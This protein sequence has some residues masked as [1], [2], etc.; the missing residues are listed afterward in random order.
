[1]SIGARHELARS[2]SSR[3]RSGSKADKS[4]ILDEFCAATGYTRKHALR[5][6]MKPPDVGHAR[7]H[8]RRASQY[9]ELEESALGRLWPVSGYLGARRLVA[10]LPTLMEALERHGE[11]VPEAA[12]RKKLTSMSVST[13]G[14][15]LKG[16]RS[17][18]KHRGMVTTKPGTLLK[19]SIAIRTGT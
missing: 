3:Y 6:V 9:T 17:R 2:V 10:A 1:M 15:L 8:R 16:I 5:L 7:R 11:W 18:F 4:R 12:I 13:C 14:R 19:K